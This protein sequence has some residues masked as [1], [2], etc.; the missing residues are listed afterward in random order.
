LQTRYIYTSFLANLFAGLA[1]E[2]AILSI[3]H[4]KQISNNNYSV[5][6]TKLIKST[7]DYLSTVNYTHGVRIPIVHFNLTFIAADIY[8]E[9]GKEGRKNVSIVLDTSIPK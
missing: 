1:K 2:G 3:H 5:S 6:Y 8:I 4:A 7:M 9:L